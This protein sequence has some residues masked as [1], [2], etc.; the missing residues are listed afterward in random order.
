MFLKP[1][2]KKLEPQ[3]V[4]PKDWNYD[5][6]VAL[7][8][9]PLLNAQ[10]DP[11]AFQNARQALLKKSTPAIK[12]PPQGH[13]DGKP[14]PLNPTQLSEEAD[15]KEMNGY[16]TATFGVP[17]L[18]LSENSH[19]I[20]WNGETRRLWMIGP[21]SAAGLLMRYA[22]TPKGAADLQTKNELIEQGILQEK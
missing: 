7:L 6:L 14:M 22:G 17:L 16:L 9:E 3:S 5:M 1:Y 11:A 18:P 8:E 10:K 4:A 12:V 19:E 21:L 15:A 20:E 2:G 13:I